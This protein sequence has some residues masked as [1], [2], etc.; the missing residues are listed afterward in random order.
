MTSTAPTDQQAQGD[1]WRPENIPFSNPPSIPMGNP[2]D[3]ESTPII[4][5]KKKLPSMSNN[6]TQ[7][8]CLITR[9][10]E[11]DKDK[12]QMDAEDAEFNAIFKPDDNLGN[13]QGTGQET[14][15]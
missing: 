4:Y 12:S 9:R 10:L 3:I 8:L 15:D 13:G 6:E 11:K 14:E 1:F 5:R 7:G 2:E